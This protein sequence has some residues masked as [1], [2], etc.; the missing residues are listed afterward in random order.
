MENNK[1]ATSTKQAASYIAERCGIDRETVVS[2]LQEFY[3][4]ILH[5]LD[6]EIPFSITGL[7]KFYYS[8]GGN[9]RKR[10]MLKNQ[11]F[12]KDKVHRELRFTISSTIKDRL[13]GWVA[14]IGLKN[15]IDKKEMM[16]L[17]ITPEQISKKRKERLLQEQQAMGFTADLIFDEEDIPI[18]D[19]VLLKDAPKPPSVEEMLDRLGRNID[20]DK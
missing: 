15:N 4:C 14:D 19:K 13:E 11:E 8:Y 10:V 16:R 9:N 18:A 20:L 3:F 5:C 2:V 1:I 6:E 12:F 17:A 7:G